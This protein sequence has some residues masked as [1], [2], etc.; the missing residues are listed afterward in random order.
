MQILIMQFVFSL[1][2]RP[3]SYAQIFFLQAYFQMFSV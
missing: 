1:L 3:L 2:L